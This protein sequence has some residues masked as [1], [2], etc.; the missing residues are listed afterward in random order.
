MFK[1]MCKFCDAHQ[2]QILQT[3]VNTRFG[4]WILNRF[5]NLFSLWQP[6]KELIG[7]GISDFEFLGFLYLVC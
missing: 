3:W 5:W 7:F 6:Q 4:V 2:G 1:D